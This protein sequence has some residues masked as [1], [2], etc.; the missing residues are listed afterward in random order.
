MKA[1]QFKLGQKVYHDNVYKCKEPLT[2]KGIMKNKLLLEGDY[3]GGVSGSIQSDWL[4]IEGVRTI[5]NY[6]YKKEC[7]NKVFR[8]INNLG[9]KMNNVENKDLKEVCE[10]VLNLT[11]DIYS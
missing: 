7:R 11:N 8:I 9:E 1:E 2:I 10:L 6:T 5:Y 3:S 4:P